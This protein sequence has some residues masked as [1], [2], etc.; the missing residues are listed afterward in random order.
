[1]VYI[2]YPNKYFFLNLGIAAILHHMNRPDSTIAVD[3]SLY[4]HHPRIHK[5]MNKYIS[6]LVPNQTVRIILFLL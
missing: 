3:G 1:M 6:L 4:K 5:W 2:L